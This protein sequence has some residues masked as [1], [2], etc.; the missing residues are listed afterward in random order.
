MHTLS[1][2]AEELLRP[3]FNT[4]DLNSYH[5]L[6]TVL[7]DVAHDS[8]TAKVYVDCLIRPVFIMTVYVRALKEKLTGRLTFWL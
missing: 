7:A 4:E 5:I 3:L 8:R 6:S 2:V 1:L